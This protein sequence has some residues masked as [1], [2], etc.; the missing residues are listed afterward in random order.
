MKSR[1]G[2][3][4][5]IAAMATGL[6]LLPTVTDLGAVNAQS[7]RVVH[8]PN[9]W[10][11][12]TAVYA[13]T[14]LTGGLTSTEYHYVRSDGSTRQDRRNHPAGDRTLIDNRETQKEYEFI[15]GGWEVRPLPAGNNRQPF[16]SM[17][18]AMPVSS[19]DPRVQ[20]V[21]G[22]GFQSFQLP[23]GDQAKVVM[24]LSPALNLRVVYELTPGIER[25][26]TSLSIGEP[27]IDFLPPADI[28]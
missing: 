4:S 19:A 21:A 24:I 22:Q 1:T 20:A 9:T 8:Q 26:L 5:I 15:R 3:I 10:V 13:V 27:T 7:S 12:L 25:K 16:G 2:V 14:T 18:D 17:S 11:P 28:R 6:M 23:L